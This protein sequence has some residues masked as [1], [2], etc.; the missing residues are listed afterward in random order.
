MS[1][2]NFAIVTVSD[3]CSA[4]EQNDESGH[5]LQ[6]LCEQDN[7]LV[8]YRKC[9]SDDLH[10]ISA[11]LIE[12]CNESN[13]HVVIT[14]GGTGFTDRDVTPEATKQIIEKEATGI[15]VALLCESIQK[16]KFAMLSRLVAGIRNSTLVVNFPGSPKACTECYTII[17]TVLK[18]AVHQLIGD[19]LS[20][21]KVHTKLIASQMK[22]K[23]CSVPSGHRLRSSAYE[24]ID[25]DVAIQMIHRESSALQ[26]I[27]TFKLNDSANLIGKI[28]AV[29]IKSQHPLPPFRA[30][31]KDGYAVIAEDGISAGEEPSKVKVVRG[32]CARINTGAPLPDG[33]DSI[34]QIEDTEV[35]ER[36]DDGE[37]SV[38]RIKKAPTLGQDIREI[39][40]DISLN[41]VVVNK[42]TKLGP[43]EL[44]LI[45]SVGCEQIPVLEKAVVAV[46]ST[47]D[48]LLDVGESYRDGAI[49]D[50]NRITLKSFLNQCNYKVVDIGIAKDNANDVCTKI[51]E[52]L[53]LA[54]VL[55]S[56][57]GVSMGDKDLVKDVLIADFGANIHFGRVNVK[58]GKPTTFATCVKN[59]K[60]KF[61]FALPGNPVS[62]FVCCFLFAIPCLRILS[63]ET[64]AKSDALEN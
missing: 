1:K 24:M 6:Q 42:G 18:H 20:V 11:L 41:E 64:F 17:R 56:T 33:S 44:G 40:S 12:L 62:A 63:A 29:D 3:R 32:K 47:G 51:N 50:A 48:E 46:L 38:I 21:S 27:A 4:G 35:A 13:V 10:Q 52:A 36:R 8:L 34:V 43:I 37:E 53:E 54:D 39:G 28:V 19:K 25:F 31:I 59:G 22:S 26:N 55:I 60:K 58:P 49:W 45:A 5:I 2:I 7:H 30:S 9:V 57:G 23:V 15:S 61:I 14:T 16:T